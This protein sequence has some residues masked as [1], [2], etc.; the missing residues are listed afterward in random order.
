MLSIISMTKKKEAKQGLLFQSLSRSRCEVQYVNTVE[1]Q[2]A[3]YRESPYG[4][5]ETDSIRCELKMI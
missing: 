2:P 5:F 1:M 4:Y 3:P